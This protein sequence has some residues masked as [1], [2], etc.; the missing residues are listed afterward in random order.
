[1]PQKPCFFI[2][3]FQFTP[4]REGRPQWTVQR[5]HS[6]RFQFTPL[7]EGRHTCPKSLA[8]SF[9]DFN[10]RPCVRGDL[11]GLSSDTIHPD[12]NSRPCVRGDLL[13]NTAAVLESYFNSRPC[14]RGD[15][16]QLNTDLPELDFNSRPC[17]RGDGTRRWPS[18]SRSRF[19]FTPLR[20]GRRS[21]TSQRYRGTSRFQF[22]PL[23]EGRREIWEEMIEAACNFNSR[24]CVRG[25]TP[26]RGARPSRYTFQFTPLREGRLSTVASLLGMSTLFQFTPLR[27]GRPRMNFVRL[28][29]LTK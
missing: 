19:Q 22:T 28:S 18:C 26:S 3:R 4:L 7:R 15:I 20:E 11:N 24:P 27:E 2:P 25:D 12:F 1:M 23:R 17:V 9:P 5:H 21:R 10:S 29:V 14:V 13:A 6:P 8:F 16:D